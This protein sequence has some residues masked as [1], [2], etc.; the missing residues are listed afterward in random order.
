MATINVSAPAVN[1]SSAGQTFVGTAGET[2]TA[3]Q[4]VYLYDSTNSVYKLADATT[5]AAKSAVRGIAQCNAFLNQS[6]IICR[7][8]PSFAIGNAT[9]IAGDIVI[10]GP[11]PGNIALST[12]ATTDFYVTVLGAINDPANG[13]MNFS[14]VSSNIV[15]P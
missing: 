12:D 7:S 1:C 14:M 4:P 2:I 11:Q 9:R 13:R 6:F 5:N 3:G 15:I 10:L 8:D